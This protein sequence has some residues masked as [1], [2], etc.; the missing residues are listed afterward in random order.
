[1][2]LKEAKGNW[3][4][5]L[6]ADERL[7]GQLRT[8]IRRVIKSD[9]FNAYAVPRK[10]MILS[11]HMK[12]GGESPDFQKRLFYKPALK[13][14]TGQV[15][16]QP[17]FT[18]EL[19]YLT[20]VLIHEKHKNIAEMMA[21]TNEWSEIEAGLLEKAGHPKMAGWRLFRVMFTETFRRLVIKLGFL[22]GPKGVIYS[23]Y[24]GYS[25]V[26]TYTKLW[27]RQLKQ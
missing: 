3:I 18:G 17:E 25:K 20:S 14:W 15:H 8:E 13:K 7:T 16:E 1:L 5:Y 2:G 4:F 23:F 24:Q 12:H 22:D 9:R 27:E 11:M 19:G 21:K 10:N 6:D 26:V